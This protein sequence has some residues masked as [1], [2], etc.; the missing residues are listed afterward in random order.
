[1]KKLT[2]PFLV[3]TLLSGI[4]LFAGCKKKDI[5][6]LTTTPATDLT[7]TSAKTGGDITDDGNTGI[8]QRGVCWSTVEDPT[9]AD[10]STSDGTGAG[11]FESTIS[12]LAE[13]TTYYVRAYATNSEGTAYGNQETFSTAFAGH[14]SVTTNEIS[15]I[16]FFTAKSGGNISDDGGGPVTARGIC[17]NTS[18][19]PTIANNFTTDGEGTGEFTSNL[20]GLQQGTTYYVRAYATNKAGTAYGNQQ[21]F[22]T[23][24]SKA[25]VLTTA[26]LTGFTVNSVVTGGNVTDDGGVDV[27]ARGVCWATTPTP[28]TA[29]SKTNN[30]TGKGAFV[31][32]VTG[33]APGTVYYIRSYATNSAGTSYGSEIKFSTSIADNEGNVYRTVAIG[34]Q[35][36][37]S[38]N[39]KSTRLNDNTPIPNVT[40]SLSWIALTTPGYSWYRNNPT[41]YDKYGVLY[42]W[43]TVATNNL[44]PSGWH[45][46]TQLEY[47][48]LEQTLGVPADSTVVWGWR[49]K[50]VGTHMKSTTGWDSLGNGDNQSGM[51]V[52]PGGYR[53]WANSQFRGVGSMTYFWTSTDDAINHKPT[54]AWYRRIDATNSKIYNATTEKSGGKS[55][56]CM[57]NP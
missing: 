46:P 50:G 32:N 17:W 7:M 47:R 13:G 38:E 18:E 24:Q 28:T 4:L 1:M 10:N 40:D 53:A 5:P 43:F 30:G 42:N 6:T 52:L 31:S 14:A 41:L 33:L 57:K 2:K 34:N 45:V 15:E 51:N 27:T 20:T 35:L 26:D 23:A 56:R 8:T 12:G 11:V 25:P 9:T 55:V 39:L 3:I 37:M 19:G 21:T 16:S 48:T 54:V 29:N 49:G 44:C 36:W 22:K